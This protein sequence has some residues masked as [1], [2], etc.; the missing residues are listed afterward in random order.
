[1]KH[2][3]IY[4]IAPSTVSEGKKKV[5]SSKQVDSAAI[6]QAPKVES[7]STRLSPH[8]ICG[9]GGAYDRNPLHKAVCEMDLAV[10]QSEL[11]SRPPEFFQRRDSKGYCPIHSACSL[12]MN[13]PQNSSIATDIVRALIASGA[14]ASICD[15]EGNTP[16]HWAARS[17]D[18]GTA[19]LLLYKNCPKDAKNERGETA[20]HWAMR[21]GRVGMPVVSMLSENGAIPSVWNNEFKRPIDIAADGFPDEGAES[22]IELKKLMSLRKRLNKEQRKILNDAA[23]QRKEAREHLLRISLQSRTLVLNHPECL[24][25]HPKSS[26]DWEAPGRITSILDR[27]LGKDQKRPAI[28]EHEITVSQ[29]FDRAKLDLLSRIHSAEYLSFVNDLSKDLERQQKEDNKDS[30]NDNG[31]MKPAVVPFTPMVSQ[32]CLLCI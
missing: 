30:T 16:L 4:F 25:H 5:P 7:F 21:A 18:K 15:S 12:C 1:M 26:S 9:P 8:P 3:R 29:E 13:D 10:V 17:G 20:L 6:P 11:T 19:E 22:V 24:E 32:D 31:T 23:E 2:T 28:L 27:L 14:E